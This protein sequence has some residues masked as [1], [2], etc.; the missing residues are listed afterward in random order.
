MIST[1]APAFQAICSAL[2]SQLDTTYE[3]RFG[4]SIAHDPGGLVIL[5]GSNDAF[6]RYASE[7][8]RLRT[9]YAGFSLASR[10]IVA[11]RTEDLSPERFAKVLGHELAHLVHRRVFGTRLSPWLSEGL[12]DA[13][14]DTATPTGFSALRGLGSIRPLATRLHQATAAGR[15]EPV[16]MVM[17]KS[18]A[19]YD[20]G[21]VSYDYET[22]AL[23]VRFLLLDSRFGSRF[24]QVLGL[25]AAAEGCDLVCL[26]GKLEVKGPELDARFREWL[27]REL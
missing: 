2:G 25:L 5:F 22:S 1:A 19:Q 9:G 18:R 12:A 15:T 4:V 21:V 7:Q 17:I 13:I 23:L 27:E 3:Q 11:V 6:N 24:R 14:G 8:T 10:S 20:K 16:A 26:F